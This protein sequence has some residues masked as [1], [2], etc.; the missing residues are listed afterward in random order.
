V[1]AKGNEY[2]PQKKLIM[3]LFY[4]KSAGTIK[5][6]IDIAWLRNFLTVLVDSNIAW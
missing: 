3:V 6:D 5:P 2:R 4:C 1:A